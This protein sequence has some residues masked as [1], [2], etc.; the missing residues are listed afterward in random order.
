MPDPAEAAALYIAGVLP[1]D[2]AA[3]VEAR[4]D[5]GDRA[6]AGEV[7]SYGAL[8]LALCD[9]SAEVAPPSGAKQALLD[10]VAGARRLVPASPSAVEPVIFRRGGMDWRPHEVR[11]I[12]YCVLRR[13]PSRDLQTTLYRL[14]PGVE[15][16]AH[17]HPVEEE[18]YVLEGDFHTHGT[19]LLAGDY[20]K[21]PAGPDHE[22]TFTRCGCLLLVVSEVRGS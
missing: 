2:E 5:A 20:V 4:L 19:T 1:P 14:A 16:P 10:R 15:I 13:D 22:P 3:A 9:G 11:G 21:A 8:L 12:E 7:A 17:P 6:L 18:C